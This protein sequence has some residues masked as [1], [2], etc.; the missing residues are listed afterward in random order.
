MIK[1]AV[2]NGAARFKFS[3][4]YDVTFIN[5]AFSN[6]W[7]KRKYRIYLDNV[8][9]LRDS[10]LLYIAPLFCVQVGGRPPPPL[11]VKKRRFF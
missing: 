4:I 10:F 11:F 8:Y 9:L 1:R 3:D 2:S 5:V 6:E 7:I